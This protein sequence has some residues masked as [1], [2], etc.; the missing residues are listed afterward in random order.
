MC[1][2]RVGPCRLL[3]V[4]RML[5]GNRSTRKRRICKRKMHGVQ[6]MNRGMR[7]DPGRIDLNLLG[8]LDVIY[9]E[10]NLVRAGLRLHLSQSAV[11]HALARLRETLGDELFVRTG[12]G[13]E[14]TARAL[15]LAPQLREALARIQQS[16]GVQPFDP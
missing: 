15:L 7:M 4:E 12:K 3:R 2:E 14:P 11:S 6:L 8:V 5:S 9:E 1:G 16:L 10:R 13:L